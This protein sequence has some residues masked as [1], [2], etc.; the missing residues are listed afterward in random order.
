MGA[1]PMMYKVPFD[2]LL[3]AGGRFR[4]LFEDEE[5]LGEY[6]GENTT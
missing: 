5:Y 1:C 2:V 3:E 4:I 6:L